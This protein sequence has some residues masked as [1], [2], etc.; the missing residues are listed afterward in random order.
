LAFALKQQKSV[1]VLDGLLTIFSLRLSPSL[2][3][4]VF[5]WFIQFNQPKMLKQFLSN[6]EKSLF[7]YNW[8]LN[9]QKLF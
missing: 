7:I 5:S 1:L 2:V 8:H 9:N 6:E 4:L 3:K